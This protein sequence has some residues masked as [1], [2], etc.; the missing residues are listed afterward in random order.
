MGNHRCFRDEQSGSIDGESKPKLQYT[1]P[2]EDAYNA[3]GDLV[4]G[5]DTMWI[6][7]KDGTIVENGLSGMRVVYA[8]TSAESERERV[9]YRI[10][11]TEG[12]ELFFTDIKGYSIQRVDKE[13]RT[14]ETVIESTE[15]IT[16][17]VE[18]GEGIEYYLADS[19][20]A[21]VVSEDTELSYRILD[22]SSTDVIWQIVYL[23]LLV[24]L[25]VTAIIVL[26]RGFCLIN[27]QSVSP[28]VKSCIGVALLLLAV[29]SVIV[30]IMLQ[31]VREQYKEKMCEQIE[32]SAYVVA[33]QLSAKDVSNIQLAE[34]F[35]TKSYRQISTVMER[36]FS[37]EVEF[38]R[39][40]YCNILVLGEEGE[41]YAVAYLDHSIGTYFPLDEY[42]T[43]E[44]C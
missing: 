3:V 1:I 13:T 36:S 43:E 28:I 39:Q 33:N 10:G 24:V 6:L 5:T 42:E 23:I 31:E 7:D 32:M 18:E 12:G 14:S 40:M 21:I 25:I 37:T 34:D 17:S 19:Y 8:V 16:V 30:S 41:A 22:K 29:V 35:H 44:V 2:Y 4:I 20:G 15:S 27:G 26:I 11:V 9:P 38:N